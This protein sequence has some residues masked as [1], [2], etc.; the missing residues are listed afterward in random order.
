MDFHPKELPIS[1]TYDLKNEKDAANAV[2]DMVKLGFEGRKDGFKVLMP[3]E[4]RL[5]KRIGYTITTGIIQGLGQVNK[6]RDITK[7]DSLFDLAPEHTNE[8]P[9]VRRIKR[10]DEQ[11][12]VY[13]D[14]A[15]GLMADLA[16]DLAGPD[17]VFHHSKLNF[18]WFDSSD[19]S[20]I[21]I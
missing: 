11:H 8:K 10:P 15:S 3:K 1:K 19:L 7:S 13:W 18:K 16:A 2:E 14:F 21:H 12:T 4:S 5:A 9:V 6:S 20:L 17:V